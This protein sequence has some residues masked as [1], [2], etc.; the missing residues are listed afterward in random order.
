[1]KEISP[2]SKRVQRSKQMENL[3][4]S[5]WVIGG[6][7]AIALLVVL[8]LI[9]STN[10]LQGPGT[11]AVDL[12]SLQGL[13]SGVTEDGHHYLGSLEAKVV[14]KE[15]E[16]L[17]CPYCQ[18]HFLQNEP[19]LIEQYI[20]PGKVRL[21]SHVFPLLG[22]ASA[23]VAEALACAADQ[24]KYW[25]YRHIAFIK[26]PL[27]SNP[28]GREQ[29][30][31]YAEL[32]GIDTAKFATC[33][34]TQRFYTDV[35]RAASEARDANVSSTPTFFINGTAYPGVLPFESNATTQGLKSI[36]DAA[37]ATQP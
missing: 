33:F 31:S 36:L 32:A 29:F 12:S 24:G 16:D 21:E 4:T 1:M 7:I 17:R 2:V 11:T 9:Q 5:P 3:Q 30:V 8:V 27:E 18:R 34:D 10:S 14:I 23:S 35:Q 6:I 15:Y 13:P 37:L 22:S 19:Q 20:R 26:Q 25:E 28:D